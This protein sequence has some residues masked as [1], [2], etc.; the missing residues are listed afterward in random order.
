MLTLATLAN[1]NKLDTK[2]QYSVDETDILLALIIPKTN[3]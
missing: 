3:T 1:A 2:L